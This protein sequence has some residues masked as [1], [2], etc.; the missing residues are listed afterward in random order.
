LGASSI[1]NTIN[2]PRQALDKRT[3]GNVLR[4]KGVSCRE[5]MEEMCEEVDRPSLAEA[6]ENAERYGRAAG[7][8]RS[9]DEI[10]VRSRYTA[11]P[12]KQA[13]FAEDIVY[14]QR[15]VPTPLNV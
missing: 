12:R 1:L 13:S 4:Q 14:W 6:K 2:L 5:M 7:F 15:R 3:V 11:E 9:A 8:D 10:Y